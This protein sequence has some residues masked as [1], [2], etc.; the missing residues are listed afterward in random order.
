M[1]NALSIFGE[2]TVSQIPIKVSIGPIT[3]STMKEHSLTPTC[4][5][6]P[7]TIAGV[8]DALCDVIVKR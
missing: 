7:H 3:T 6:D 8:V 1:R 4:E 2:E 5:A